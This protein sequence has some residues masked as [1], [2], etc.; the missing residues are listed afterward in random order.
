MEGACGK[1]VKESNGVVRKILRKK[2]KGK[3][4]AEQYIIQELACRV[5][6]EAMLKNIFVPHVYSF[7]KNSY[8]MDCI[9]TSTPIYD[10]EVSVEA[11]KELQIFCEE[12]EKKGYFANDI[13]CYLQANGQIAII[14]FDKCEEVHNSEVRKANPFV[15][16]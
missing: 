13:E 9:D 6:E 10:V 11:K 5:V 2:Y 16:I 1:I 8:T 3:S 4:A 12:F 15:P 14:D 7:N